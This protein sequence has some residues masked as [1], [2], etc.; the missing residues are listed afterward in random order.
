MVAG[1]GRE[2][3]AAHMEMKILGVVCGEFAAVAEDPDK[4]A[5]SRGAGWN[6][7]TLRL[8]K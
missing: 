4:F 7:H 6:H 8:R 1:R 2:N 5:T 3:N